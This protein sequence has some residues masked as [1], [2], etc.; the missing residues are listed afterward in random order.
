M[1]GIAG[2]YRLDD[3]PA[4]AHD[5]DHML[6]SIAHRGPDGE[7]KWRAGPV[8]F[9]HQMRHTTPESIH[10]HLPLTADRE[11]L[12]LTCD[13]R[14]DNRDELI[15]A[16]GIEKAVVTDDEVIMAA[17]QKWGEGCAEK[18]LGDFVFAVWSAAQQTLFIARDHFGYK[19]IYYYHCPDRVF[20]FASEQKALFCLEDVPCRLNETRIGDYL[21]D[22]LDD[23]S[24]TFHRDI[25]RLPPAHVM[26]INRNR[27]QIRRYWSLD[28][29][30]ELRM[31]NDQEY[32]DAFRELF[33]EAVRCRMR[34][35]GPM[36]ILLSGGVDSSSVACTIQKLQKFSG[37]RQH[38]FSAVWNDF[39]EAQE[40]P[41]IKAVVDQ[42]GIDPHYIEGDRINPLDQFEPLFHHVDQPADNIFFSLGWF[43]K[44]VVRS[45]SVRVLMDGCAGDVTVSYAFTYLADLARSGRWLTLWKEASA[46]SQRYFQLPVSRWSILQNWAIRPFIP[47]SLRNTWR[48]VR[49][50]KPAPPGCF[51]IDLRPSFA[52]RI[53]LEDRLQTHR[54]RLRVTRSAKLDH[55]Y[56]FEYGMLS[57][58]LEFADKVNAAFGCE[59]RSPYL[60]KRLVEFCVALPR[61]QR[62]ADGVNRVVVR[63]AMTGIMPEL[64]R[65]RITKG[66][67]NRNFARALQSFGQSQM[68]ESILRRTSVLEPYLDLTAL[69]QSYERFLTG[70]SVRDA[71][72]VW[73]AI[74]LERWLSFT[75]ITP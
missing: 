41:Y 58:A 10:E 50:K 46:L 40:R 11:Q 28:P 62:I 3:Q 8:A 61:E 25:L 69:R 64:V 54:D 70:G 45:N 67:P 53:G 75:R 24:I 74:S 33:T 66:D 55:I 31:K 49:G 5:L 44:G 27:I 7:G 42:G 6:A 9:G 51:K 48:K 57:Y 73:A 18:L 72:R 37:D 65:Q 34:A 47:P 39:P 36:G 20:A 19:P 22:I 30:R 71:Y 52:N 12:I 56:G 14:I 21:T 13:A 17:Y 29:A 35:V 60:D 38:S 23:E 16:L 26:T 4:G 43:L 68:Q 59:G 32:A 15:A 1:S 63:R 2:I